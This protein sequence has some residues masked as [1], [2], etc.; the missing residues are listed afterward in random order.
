MNFKILERGIL[1]YSEPNFCVLFG[2]CGKFED[3]E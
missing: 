2:Q 1:N 3:L